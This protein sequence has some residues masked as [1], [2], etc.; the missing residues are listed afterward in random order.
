MS[1]SCKHHTSEIY[2]H[3]EAIVVARYDDVEKEQQPQ[4]QPPS[5]G[6]PL[7]ARATRALGATSGAHAILLKWR[8]PPD[9]QTENHKDG[10]SSTNV[11]YGGPCHFGNTEHWVPLF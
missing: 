5:L 1:I 6:A 2:K 10:L 11:Q 7:N 8:A 3:S 4:L 9:H